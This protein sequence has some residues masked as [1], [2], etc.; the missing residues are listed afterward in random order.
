MVYNESDELYCLDQMYLEWSDNGQGDYR[1]SPTE[2][3]MPDGTFVD[4]VYASTGLSKFGTDGLAVGLWGRPDAGGHFAGYNCQG[5]L[6]L[7]YGFAQANVIT[8]RAVLTN[9]AE[10]LVIRRMM[11]MM[12]D[13]SDEK[14]HLYTLDGDWIKEAHL[15][16]RPVEYGVLT[17][18]SNTGASSNRHNPAFMLAAAAA[19]EETGNVYGFNLVYSGNHA[20]YIEKNRR[21]IVR[22][23]TGINPHCFEWVL[24][25]GG[26]FETPEAV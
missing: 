4:F 11:S 1:Q 24:E 21:D 9:E 20:S 19:T 7:Y 16:C 17:N 2:L 14:F 12:V 22:V 23:A 3:K 25:Q 15:H 13:L 18:A 5:H 10:P 6:S 8:R 26:S